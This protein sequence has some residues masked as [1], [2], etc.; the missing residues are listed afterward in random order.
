MK[1]AN[2]IPYIL[3][4]FIMKEKKVNKDIIAKIIF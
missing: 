2:T 4:H 3:L 1:G